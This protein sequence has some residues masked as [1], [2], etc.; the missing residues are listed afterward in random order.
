MAEP[1]RALIDLVFVYKK[2]WDGMDP[3]LSSLR[4]EPDSLGQIDKIILSSLKNEKLSR[5]VNRF[6]D[7]LMKDLKS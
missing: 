7:G 5:R 4:V 6:I 3:L 2:D 1:T